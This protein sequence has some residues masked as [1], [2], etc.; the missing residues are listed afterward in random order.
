MFH[1]LPFLEISGNLLGL[2]LFK[3]DILIHQYVKS[4]DKNVWNINMEKYSNMIIEKMECLKQ[5]YHLFLW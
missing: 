2:Q 3:T 4:L 5:T 1:Q